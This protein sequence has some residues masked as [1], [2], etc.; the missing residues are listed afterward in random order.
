MGESV[1]LYLKENHSIFTLLK[2]F[3]SR[4]LKYDLVKLKKFP[5]EIPRYSCHDIASNLFGF[6][7][8]IKIKVCVSCCQRIRKSTVKDTNTGMIQFNWML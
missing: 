6:S 5:L 7:N 2:Y 8:K 4:R 1:M 3:P